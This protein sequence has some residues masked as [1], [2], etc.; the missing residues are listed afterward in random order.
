MKE[1]IYILN[2]H[3]KIRAEA[4]GT[5]RT[6]MYLYISIISRHGMGLISCLSSKTNHKHG[7][8]LDRPNNNHIYNGNP[9]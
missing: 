1:I 7:L 6:Y 8:I 5:I 2:C 3:P 4:A 9:G